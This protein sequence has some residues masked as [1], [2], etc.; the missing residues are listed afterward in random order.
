MQA[1]EHKSKGSSL[2]LNHYQKSKILVSMAP[3]KGL[4]SSKFFSKK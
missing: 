1:T 3:Q 4:M 2:A